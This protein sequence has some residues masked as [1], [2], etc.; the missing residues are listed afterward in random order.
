MDDVSSP[1]VLNSLSGGCQDSCCAAQPVL[2]AV[3]V[4]SGRGELVRRAFWLEYATIAWMVVEAIVAIWSG[5]Q[6]ASVCLLAFG[7][8][9]LIEL[10][11]AGVLI[12]RLT[13]ELRRGQVFAE[14]AERAASRIAGGLLF[15]LAAYVVA[16]AA[17]KLWTQTGET[18]AW[19]GL[20]VTMLAMPVMYVL[21]RRKIAVAEA[22]CSRAMRAD[23]MESVTC[24]WLSLVVAVGL[25]AEGL[26]G[27]WW[28]DAV[29]SLGIVWFLVKEGREAWS[30]ED[31]CCD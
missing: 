30:G 2:A 10:A 25:V 20:F 7:I 24:G 31:C 15:V 22:L 3:A 6:A 12:W 13:A 19:P 11:S 5:V 17:W 21:A 18:F 1:S 27:A 14:S 26:T 9:S 23:A 4:G 29:T 8:D 16:A 28:V